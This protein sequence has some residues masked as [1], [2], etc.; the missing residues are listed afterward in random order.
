MNRFFKLTLVVSLIFLLSFI[1]LGT[2]TAGTKKLSF[3]MMMSQAHPH[4]KDYIVPITKMIEDRTKGRVKVSIKWG[5]ALGAAKDQYFVIRDGIAD[6][7]YFVTG[8]TPG[9]FPTIEVA[10]LPFAASSA[11]NVNKALAAVNEAGLFGDE[12]KEII[13]LHFLAS[14]PYSFSCPD[15]NL[16]TLDDFNGKKMRSPGAIQNKVLVAL[17]SSPTVVPYSEAYTALQTGLVDC[18]IN[19]P[20]TILS[21]KLFEVSKNF[22]NISFSFYGGS[23]IAM[24]KR[25]KDKVSAEDYQIIL[26]IFKETQFLGAEVTDKGEAAALEELKTLG[27]KVT[28]LSDEVIADFKKTTLPVWDQ[29]IAEME[30]RDKPGKKIVEVFVKTLQD[31]G[32]KPSYI[33]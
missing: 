8:Y 28:S 15:I 19:G 12:Y 16:M 21:S 20:A 23:V 10:S 31:L 24:N 27:V 2:V 9:R 22:V 17:G 6:M 7:G 30:D 29:W 3:S 18:W 1:S 13:P 32:D 26:D 5:D 14:S 11:V 33:K 4:S 25:V